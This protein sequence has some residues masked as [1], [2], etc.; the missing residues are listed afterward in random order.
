M[1]T[2]LSTVG[3]RWIFERS[4]Y[5]VVNGH[6][7]IAWFPS[8]RFQLTAGLGLLEELT[9][10]REAVELFDGRKLSVV[11]WTLPEK[12]N[13]LTPTY[14]AGASWFFTQISQLRLSLS[15]I[16]GRTLSAPGF[17][18]FTI[19]PVMRAQLDFIWFIDGVKY[20]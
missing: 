19:S 18:P 5:T 8:N 2:V 15:R 17:P 1:L 12:D 10:R 11:D 16:P 4:D 9:N 3:S 14:R 20:R 7:E 13:R 6:L